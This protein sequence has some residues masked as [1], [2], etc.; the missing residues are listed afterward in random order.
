MMFIVIAV[1][2]PTMIV[3]YSG[4]NSNDA[5]D[6]GGAIST[7]KNSLA[8]VGLFYKGFDAI[9]GSTVRAY[10]YSWALFRLIF[11][12]NPYGWQFTKS[13]MKLNTRKISKM[14]DPQTDC[15]VNFFQIG[16]TDKY[17]YFQVIDTTLSYLFANYAELERISPRIKRKAIELERLTYINAEIIFVPNKEVAVELEIKYKVFAK[18]I[19]IAPWSPNNVTEKAF[20]KL[21]EI[22]LNSL[23]QR[24]EILFIGK[25]LERKRIDK[26]VKLVNLLNGRGINAVLNVV[27]GIP[28]SD[29]SVTSNFVTY[30]GFLPNKS[31]VLLELLEK[32]HIGLL[33]SDG[34]AIGISL[35]EFQSAGLLTITS[36]SGGT[37][38]SLFTDFCLVDDSE[39]LVK[40]IDFITSFDFRENAREIFSKAISQRERIV[41][42][43]EIAG[44]IQ[45]NA[46]KKS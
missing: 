21:L 1:Y 5:L 23:N 26:A 28:R 24:L 8:E 10:K 35:L 30:Y 13:A 34:E 36:G 31:K 41:G 3:V 42:F 45:K 11:F 16:Y 44:Q 38:S 18:K 46:L 37:K 43:K 40:S 14:I 20:D 39:D 19:R 15:V 4:G 7:F 29:K 12:G 22:K 6:F 33:F 9:N 25:D 32:S 27:G 2:H 17:R